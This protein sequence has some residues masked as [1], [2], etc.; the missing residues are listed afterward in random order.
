MADLFGTKGLA[1]L[2]ALDLDSAGRA[3]VDSELRMLERL[4]KEIAAVHET[5]AV[6]GYDDPRVRLLMTLPGVDVAVA[7][8]LLAAL[9]NVQRFRDGD[10]A[11]SYVGLVPST[12]Q[13]ADKCYHGPITKQGNGQAR[14]MLVQAAQHIGAQPGPLGVF[15]RRLVTKKNH[16]V[17][18]VA[19]ARK[20]VVI[21]W[22]MLKNNEPYRYAVPRSVKGKLARHRV[23]VTGKSWVG[24]TQKGQPRPEAYGTGKQ[25]YGIP[26]LDTIYEREG[27][28]PLKPLPS[29]ETRML[30]DQALLPFAEAT[31]RATRIPRQRVPSAESASP[32]AVEAPEQRARSDPRRGAQAAKP[33]T[34]QKVRR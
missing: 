12:R 15:Y 32:P 22:H 4:D 24:G 9:G 33:K 8:A 19:T 31:R 5:L 25:T 34:S 26:S 1:W 6:D 14:W 11:A 16:A 2:R 18:V 29:G 17:A 30:S 20:L 27:L 23:K 28:P 13:S 3:A 10:H 21:A 7:Q